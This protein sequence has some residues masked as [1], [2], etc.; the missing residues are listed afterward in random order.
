M[1]LRLVDRVRFAAL[2]DAFAEVDHE[3]PGAHSD[4]EEREDLIGEFLDFTDAAAHEPP[5]LIFTNASAVASMA[6]S[7]ARYSSVSGFG[8]QA[9]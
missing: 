3:L 8:S 5:R 2:Y 7:N 1:A 6:R 9:S 4:A